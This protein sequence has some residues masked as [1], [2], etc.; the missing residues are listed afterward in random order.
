METMQSRLRDSHCSNF[1]YNTQVK[2]A[3]RRKGS[4][5]LH[6]FDFSTLIKAKA[7]DDVKHL[8]ERSQAVPITMKLIQ[9][10]F[11]THRRYTYIKNAT[12]LL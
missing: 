7:K 10:K 3:Y 11:A 6:C 8:L 1:E 9:E 12:V 5:I 2:N 4:L